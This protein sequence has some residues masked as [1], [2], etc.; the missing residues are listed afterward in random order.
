VAGLLDTPKA[1]F[2][3]EQVNSEY[4]GVDKEDNL[5][6]LSKDLLQTF[7]IPQRLV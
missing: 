4:E 3:R 6:S 1:I 7:R 5:S 2:G